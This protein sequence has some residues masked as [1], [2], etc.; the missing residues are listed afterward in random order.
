[1]TITNTGATDIAG[2]T[3][4]FRLHDGQ[5]VGNGWN[6]EWA[7]DGREVTVSDVAFDHDVAAGDSVTLG[8]VGL[9]DGSDSSGSSDGGGG[10]SSAG[11]AG[12]AGDTAGVPGSFSLNGTDCDS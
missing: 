11:S 12:S 1:M 3:L 7:Q 4:Q 8:F 2:W 5:Q 6:G 10:G 9:S